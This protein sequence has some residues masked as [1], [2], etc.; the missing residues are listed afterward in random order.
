[1]G[2]ARS[3]L[4]IT[5]MLGLVFIVSAVVTLP[6]A[7]QGSPPEPAVLTFGLP[8]DNNAS[9]P[10]KFCQVTPEG[11]LGLTH[12]TLRFPA[13]STAKLEWNTEHFGEAPELKLENNEDQIERPGD[14][15]SDYTRQVTATITVTE[16]GKPYVCP[17]VTLF[18]PFGNPDESAYE[19]WVKE[20]NSANQGKLGELKDWLRKARR[21][22]NAAPEGDLRKRREKRAQ[23]EILV[24]LPSGQVAPP[25]P[26]DITEGE[27]IQ[28][29]IIM[30]QGDHKVKLNLGTCAPPETF[31]IKTDVEGGG[32]FWATGQ[33]GEPDFQILPVGPIAKCGPDAVS[34]TIGT[35]YTEPANTEVAHK[36]RINPKYHIAAI[37]A[38]GW[39]GARG[40]RFYAGDSPG[41]GDDTTV[42]RRILRDRTTEGLIAYVGAQWM[43]GGVDYRNM[44]PR[45][46]FAN[47]FVAVN[48]AAP[49]NDIAWGFTFTPSGGLGL[50]IGM[51]L[52]QST[53]LVGSNEVLQP[54][55]TGQPETRTTWNNPNLGYFIGFAV[56]TNVFRAL[57]KANEG[58][59]P[60]P[61][62]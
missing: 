9:V 13:N 16:G 59:V 1:M 55:P 12:V 58:A 47:L 46:Y 49:L 23:P 61:Q 34:Y 51:T 48:P 44:R 60:V 18:E 29:A 43:I 50:S 6:A 37:V 17:N 19:W 33:D 56:D 36:L 41:A 42:E 21:K 52:H 62:D 45:N 8:V 35:E 53:E 54:L 30:P 2:W 28:M 38:L 11:D 57:S 39:D 20:L 22:G 4:A 7:A 32:T 24:H 25:F 26:A 10:R 40:Q 3:D 31:R 27:S 14:S 15:P 5:R